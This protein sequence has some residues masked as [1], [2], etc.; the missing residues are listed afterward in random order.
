MTTKRYKS[1]LCGRLRLA[2]AVQPE[3]QHVEE[4]HPKI[5]HIQ[6]RRRKR[7]AISH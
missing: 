4:K 5:T 6:R 3:Q 1:I 2:I 7:L